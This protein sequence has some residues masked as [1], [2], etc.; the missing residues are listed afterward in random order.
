MIQIT[1][2][3]RTSHTTKIKMIQFSKNH[4][5]N[6]NTLY[7]RVK[8]SMARKEKSSL[9]QF[10]MICCFYL[11]KEIRKKTIT[12]TIKDKLVAECSEHR[13]KQFLQDI[14]NMS[15]EA[16]IDNIP[17]KILHFTP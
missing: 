14:K 3:I 11:V 7:G 1:F 17:K 5:K 13:T 12:N 2:Y 10:L 4:E 9:E 16:K 6:L 8:E 15:I